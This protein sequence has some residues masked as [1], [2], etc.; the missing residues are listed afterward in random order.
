MVLYIQYREYQGSNIPKDYTL[1]FTHPDNF[2]HCLVIKDGST[3]FRYNT[4]N[5]KGD[6]QRYSLPDLQSLLE[7]ELFQLMCVWE[8][9]ITI[10]QMI[11]L[12]KHLKYCVNSNKKDHD[13]K[14]EVP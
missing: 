13:D 6:V 2:D 9:P 14:I 10:D 8:H 7:E 3:N 12:Q 1:Y 4:Y 11:V 5:E